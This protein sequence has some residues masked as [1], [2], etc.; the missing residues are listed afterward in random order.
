MTQP[1]GKFKLFILLFAG[2][3]SILYLTG[4]EQKTDKPEDIEEE[5]ILIDTSNVQPADTMQAE[6]DT[7]VDLTGRWTGTFDQRSTTLNITEHNE[8]EFKGTITI[9]YRDPLT[10]AVSGKFDNE[11]KEFTMADTQHGRYKG[12]Y[13]GKFEDGKISGTFTMDLDGKN[14]SFNLTKK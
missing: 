8:T 1:M 2:V 11:K 5:E 6:E 3:F 13:K 9:S 4:C 7:V 10:K 14:Y 12:N